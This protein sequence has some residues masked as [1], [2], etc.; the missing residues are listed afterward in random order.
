MGFMFANNIRVEGN[1]TAVPVRISGESIRD[2]FFDYLQGTC[3]KH[4]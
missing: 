4:L 2:V 3:A 1:M